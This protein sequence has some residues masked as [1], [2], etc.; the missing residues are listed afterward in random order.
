MNTDTSGSSSEQHASHIKVPDDLHGCHKLI[1]KTRKALQAVTPDHN[2]LVWTRMTGLLNVK[3]SRGAVPRALRIFQAIIT[4]AESRGWK[5]KAST[6]K[7]ECAIAIGEDDV[8]LRLR[9]KLKRFENR[10]SSSSW[11]SY[12]FEPTGQLM[13]EITC[14]V[15]TT[16]NRGWWDTKT[17]PLENQIN[18]VVEGIGTAGEALRKLK[19]EQAERE[20]HWKEE[21]AKRH[22]K[23]AP[24]WNA[25]CVM[26]YSYIWNCM[27]DLCCLRD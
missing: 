26:S 18:D 20:K 11:T 19:I 15:G 24:M 12:T 23:N 1:S 8:T 17:W 27:N 2:S 21:Q 25:D 6:E 10:S 22:C 7:S 4:G 5:V 3:V 14:Y 9:E 13:L 16:N